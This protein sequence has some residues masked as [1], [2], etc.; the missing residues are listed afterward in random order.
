LFPVLTPAQLARA[1]RFG[2]AR[3]CDLGDVLL[4]AGAQTLSI[5]IVVR[6][7]VDIVRLACDEERIVAR[8]SPG[9][10]TGEAS[11]LAGQPALVSIRAAAPSD[12]IEVGRE[13]LLRIV[14]T[15]SE[16]SDG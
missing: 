6:G 4:A 3:S 10:F 13:Q 15:D 16:L 9:Q 11:T 14:Q 2:S 7:L 5:F 1:A 12:V 8:L